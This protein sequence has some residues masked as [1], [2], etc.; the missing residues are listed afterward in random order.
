MEA[1][2]EH[3]RDEVDEVRLR[4]HPWGIRSVPRP[5]T[6]P[7]RPSR[8]V[9]RSRRRGA[10]TTVVPRWTPP[11][12]PPPRR[13][14]V[15]RPSDWSRRAPTARRAARAEDRGISRA[16]AHARR[17]RRAPRP[18]SLARLAIRSPHLGPILMSEAVVCE[19]SAITRPGS[20]EAR[21]SSTAVQRVAAR[22]RGPLGFVWDFAQPRGA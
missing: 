19:G 3:K 16:D 20:I 10:R 2:L 18:A 9:A 12:G 13:P 6:T 1:Y 4:P 5:M 17:R 14:A 22:G 21:T 11:S 8:P 15:L 7:A